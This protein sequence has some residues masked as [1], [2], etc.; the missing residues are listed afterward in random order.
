MKNYVKFTLILSSLLTFATLTSCV[1]LVA[2][3][4][5]GYLLKDEGYSV[6][7]PITKE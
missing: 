2:G 1:P 5:G 4:A 7:S 6:Q 3:A